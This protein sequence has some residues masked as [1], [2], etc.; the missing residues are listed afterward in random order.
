MKK[1]RIL[2]LHQYFL[3]PDQD[4][5]HRIYEHA[6][7]LSNN[8]FEVTVITSSREASQKKLWE[9]QQINKYLS[10]H[11]LKNDGYFHGRKSTFLS[12]LKSFIYFAFHST[13]KSFS[14]KKDI[15]YA[16]STPLTIV[17]PALFQK[18]L[19][20]KKYIFEVRDMWP[21][22]PVKM[23][24]IKNPILIFMSYFL[25][26]IAYFFSS[27][28]VVVSP[29][30][31]DEIIKKGFKNKKIIIV[32]NGCD[33]IFLFPDKENMSNSFL[34]SELAKKKIILYAGSISKIY[35]IEFLLNLGKELKTTDED[36]C[37]LVA[38]RGDM[39][40]YMLEKAKELNILN[41][42]LFFL[43]S[44][45]KLNMPSVYNA[46]KASLCIGS[47]YHEAQKH[48]VNNKFF[49]SIASGLPI[50]TNF[51]SFQTS[52]A[53]K[54]NFCIRVSEN[55]EKKSVQ[56]IVSHLNDS[57]WMNNASV[58][59]RNLA[60]SKYNRNV[61]STKIIEAINNA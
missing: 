16:T 2:I 60:L 18:F 9:L 1:N 24:I 15:V 50:I 12:R 59:A 51:D 3:T 23:G 41:K 27:T 55:D 13:I 48:A 21:D 5:A 43:G 4:G 40:D 22:V 44:V 46:S 37:I 33:E 29:G 28:I 10:V 42:S 30:M 11:R 6:L 14:I 45:P 25:E 32:E 8:G 35:G 26:Y 20:G 49:D 56:S 19:L 58:N 7:N 34:P 61:Q 39:V 54:N 36:I 53:L 52:L 38:G 47:G 57:G 31:K 17:L